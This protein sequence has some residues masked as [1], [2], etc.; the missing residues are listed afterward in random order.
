MSEAQD[1]PAEAA[2]N[3]APART[4]SL[5]DTL[6]ALGA[7]LNE[8]V[9]RP[10]FGLGAGAMAELRRLSPERPAGAAFH[11]MMLWLE[12]RGAL[13]SADTVGRDD[14]ERDWAVI[15]N[16]MALCA[17]LHR[18]G[19]PA[20]KALARCMGEDRF[21][22]LTQAHGAQL[23]ARVRTAARQLAASGQVLDWSD[24]AR[25]VL[26]DGRRDQDLARRD[27]ARAFFSEQHRSGL[28]VQPLA[29]E[30]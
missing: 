17:G 29:D 7:L 2:A 20:G 8:A 19:M 18:A 11:R 13:R 5:F 15:L 6:H 10:G 28:A 4:P 9:D 3:A 16:G 14:E 30:P 21:I 26:T 25:L 12:E 27:L 1:I 24:L 23:H 22:A